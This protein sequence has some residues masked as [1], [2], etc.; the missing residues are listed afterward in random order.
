MI[1]GWFLVTLLEKYTVKEH[2]RLICSSLRVLRSETSRTVADLM[3]LESVF[4]TLS[5]A[6]ELVRA[7]IQF[8]TH[9]T[10]REPNL[11]QLNTLFIYNYNKWFQGEND[12]PYILRTLGPGDENLFNDRGIFL[13]KRA[14]ILKEIDSE[15]SNLLIVT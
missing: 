4:R 5:E 11:T 2:W 13:Q 9:F 12:S 6:A 10:L 3:L 15:K 7:E 14:D 8:S 1:A